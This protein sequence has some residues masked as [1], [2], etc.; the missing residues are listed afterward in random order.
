MILYIIIDALMMENEN[1][2]DEMSDGGEKDLTEHEL[3][4]D[5]NDRGAPNEIMLESSEK[6]DV[7][8]V[9]EK[10]FD[11]HYYE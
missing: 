1:I 5:D 3:N 4:E 11:P 8:K 10:G 2:K 9:G 7:I 6:I